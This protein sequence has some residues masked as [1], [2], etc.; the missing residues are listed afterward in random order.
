MLQYIITK[1]INNMTDN[2][3]TVQNTLD[4]FMDGYKNMINNY[5]EISNNSN[6]SDEMLHIYFS[7]IRSI[8]YKLNLLLFDVQDTNINMLT[9]KLSGLNQFEQNLLNDVNKKTELF[10]T[11]LPVI[12]MFEYLQSQSDM[13]D[14]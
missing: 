2:I 10:N 1:L 3:T 11:Y 4:H 14:D 9:Q 8:I 13:R 7:K 5:Q 12:A 6:I